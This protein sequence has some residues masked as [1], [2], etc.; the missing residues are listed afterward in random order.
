MIR[1]A[2]ICENDHGFE[3]WFANSDA[4]DDQVAQG[5]IECP[6]CGSQVI[7]KQIMAPAVAGRAREREAAAKRFEQAAAAVRQHIADTHENVGAQFAETARAIHDGD[8]PERP[9]YGE[10]T[11]TETKSLIDDG[12]NVAPLPDAF[13][14]KPAKKLN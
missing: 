10:A 4:Y 2:L 11:Q 6:H 5:L 9:I 12:V 3:A 14:P 7:R 1:Y 8:A 13:V